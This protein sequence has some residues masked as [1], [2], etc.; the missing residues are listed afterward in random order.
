VAHGPIDVLVNNAGFEVAGLVDSLADDLLS[1]QFD[2]NVFR[3]VRMVRAASPEMRARK[4]A[5]IANLSSMVGSLTSL[6]VFAYAAGKHAVESSSE[7]LRFELA[8]V[9]VRGMIVDAY[10]RPSS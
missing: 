9:G 10:C 8:P 2:T 5:A 7:V 3:V 4:Q 6:Y 1:R